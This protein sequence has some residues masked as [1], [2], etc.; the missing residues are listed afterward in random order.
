MEFCC[1]QLPATYCPSI[2]KMNVGNGK[3]EF[4]GAHVSHAL[5]LIYIVVTFHGNLN[6]WGKDLPEVF[7]WNV[8]SAFGYIKH[9]LAAGLHV[10][11]KYILLF[12]L[13]YS[14]RFILP[15]ILRRFTKF[16][17]SFRVCSVCSR[18]THSR[19]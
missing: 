14:N 19:K 12:V 16:H 2:A 9:S 4:G 18:S 11:M 17:N 6:S 1:C 10:H 13:M 5:D 8:F 7:F 15:P 3:N